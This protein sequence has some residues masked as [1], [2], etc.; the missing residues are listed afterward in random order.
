MRPDRA[1]RR[2]GGRAVT[3]AALAPALLLLAAMTLPLAP[4]AA[5]AQERAAATGTPAD[6]VR[7]PP[8]AP[9]SAHAGAAADSA[10]AAGGAPAAPTDS[11][12]A[13]GRPKTLQGELLRFHPGGARAD[14]SRAPAASAAAAPR[15]RAALPHGVRVDLDAARREGVF[16]PDAA[17]RERRAVVAAPLPVFGPLQGPLALPDG[18]GSL[19]VAGTAGHDDVATDR[20]LVAIPTAGLLPGFATASTDPLGADAELFDDAALD[21]PAEP[22]RL[23]GPG[24]ALARAVPRGVADALAQAQ[25]R[26]PSQFR[27]TLIYGKGDGGEL[28][29]GARFIAP[30]LLRGVYGSFAR[31]ESGGTDAISSAVTSRYHLVAGL[32]RLLSRTFAVDARLLQGTVEGSTLNPNGSSR[33][34]RQ[35]AELSLRSQGVFGRR[36]EA[37]SLSITRTKR[38]DVLPPGLGRERWDLPSLVASGDVAW[39]DSALGSVYVSG[40]AASTRITYRLGASPEFEPRREEARAAAGVRRRMG[41]AGVGA[42]GAYDWRETE[43]GAWDARLSGWVDARRANARLDLESVHERPSWIDRLTPADTSVFFTQTQIVTIA[44]AGNPGL[45]PRR[46][47]GAVAFGSWEAAPWL[48]LSGSGSLRRV[49]H[50]FGWDLTWSQAPVAVNVTDLAEDRGSGWLS[51]ASLAGDVHA[52]PVTGH[53]L[54]WS[55]FGPDAL[56]PRAASP[57]RRALEADVGARVVLFGGDLPLRAGLAAHAVGPRRGLF[58]EPSQITWDGSLRLDLGAA[59]VAIE[60]RNL[61]D[62]VVGSTM[63]DLETGRPLPLPGRTLR[64][65][66]VWNLLD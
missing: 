6:S 15:P 29:T 58:S 56:S 43:G 16:E 2:R 3:R 23:D 30:L 46:L 52:G 63:L 33:T 60:M 55:R 59:G 11:L 28:V 61:F 31:H 47:T 39:G 17:L 13:P 19:R 65:G 18:G 64:L 37:W 51:H 20:T 49:T 42:D 40:R 53:V 66:I 50:D 4:G 10:R 44:R 41:P 38:T 27:S 14:T 8:A 57:P 45:G 54:A 25:G 24:D 7:V 9:D 22:G 32:P 34:E 1:G 36:S 62:R 21:F 48:T 26:L 12:H 35:R 5:G